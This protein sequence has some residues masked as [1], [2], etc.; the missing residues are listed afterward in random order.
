MSSHVAPDGAAFGQFLAQL[1][2]C[3]GG[4]SGSNALGFAGHCDWRLPTISELWSL[5]DTSVPG[6]G[7][8]PCIDPIFGPTSLGS[9]WSISVA[10]DSPTSGLSV[11]AFAAG[12]FSPIAGDLNSLAVRAVRGG[13]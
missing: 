3:P 12:G 9:Y 10:P 7:T 8:V 11:L 5:V 6:C 2:D 1:N 13:W 4:P